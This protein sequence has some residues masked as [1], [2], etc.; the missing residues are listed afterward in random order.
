MEND[1]KPDIVQYEKSK[2]HLKY[3]IVIA[4]ILFFG[5]IVLATA[6]QNEFVA[7]VSFGST[8]TSIILS[9]VAIW[10][11]ISGER[12]TNDIR[13]KI[14]DSTERLSGTTKEIEILNNNHKETLNT[15]INE[16]KNVQEKL[17][18]LLYS[19][20]DIKEKVNSMREGFSYNFN[21][22]SNNSKPDIFSN[23]F[24]W[25]TQNYKYDSQWIFCKMVDSVIYYYDN[26]GQ[27][28]FSDIIKDLLLSSVPVP[29]YRKDIENYWGV[30][31][32][33]AAASLFFNES[34]KEIKNLIHPILNKN[35]FE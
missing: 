28:Y 15:Q 20:G 18:E 16:L 10:M 32:T 4:T 34:K 5:S 25:I 24:S 3:I 30:I 35:P 12:T 13:F 23:V 29:I 22:Q 21:K 7:Q 14:S 31:N 1:K 26:I 2:L 11:S 33:L 9:V 6:N 27:F 17:N 19:V 8:I